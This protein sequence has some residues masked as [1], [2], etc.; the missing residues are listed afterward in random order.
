MNIFSTIVC[1][2]SAKRTKKP[3]GGI[4]ISPLLKPPLNDKGAAAPFDPRLRST[5]ISPNHQEGWDWER[6]ISERSKAEERPP[7]PMTFGAFGHSKVHKN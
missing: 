7:T 1:S 4:S 2:F 3:K 5:L 6:E